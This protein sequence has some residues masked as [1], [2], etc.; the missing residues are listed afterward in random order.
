VTACAFVLG[1]SSRRTRARSSQAG[2]RSGAEAAAVELG[3][4]LHERDALAYHGASDDRARLLPIGHGARD[5]LVERPEIVPVRLDDPPTIG[6]EVVADA[7]GHDVA[8]AAGYLDAVEVHYGREIVEAVL[9]GEAAGLGNLTLVL[10]AVRHRHERA[11][12][13][14]G[15]TRGE[16][17]ADTRGEP[18]AEVPGRPFDAGNGA[19]DV[20]L[21]RTSRLPEVGHGVLELEEP[22]IRE[23][24]VDSGRRVPVA[25]D[26]AV[27]SGPRRLLGTKPRE[28]VEQEVDL[29][30]GQGAARVT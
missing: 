19:F 24:D 9:H 30:R 15:E 1:A 17:H 2:S 12:T 13:A 20:A 8:R 16:S 6:G 22:G 28:V 11:P 21:E 27:A 26:D 10:L 3:L 25:H 18:L 5:R 14:A 29:H 7:H 4:T 23:R